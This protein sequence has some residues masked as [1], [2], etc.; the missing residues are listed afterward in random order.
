[1]GAILNFLTDL[2]AG[3]SVSLPDLL[4]LL[5]VLYIYK[6]SGK[7]LEELH[8]WLFPLPS[9]KARVAH[10]QSSLI[11]ETRRA[12]DYRDV[13]ERALTRA[14]ELHW[15][16]IAERQKRSTLVDMPQSVALRDQ[17]TKVA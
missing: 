7:Y 16:L 6:I 11:E 4:A 1:M 12:A 17:S 10:L 2:F 3:R 8:F 14:N 13:A 9:L 5:A 15:D